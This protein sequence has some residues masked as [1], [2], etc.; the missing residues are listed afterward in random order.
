MTVPALEGVGV[1]GGRRAVVRLYRVDGP[2]RFRSGRHELAPDWRR[3]VATRGA[4][5]LG[6]DGVRIGTVEHLLAALHV[7]GVFAG[8]LIEVIGDELPILDGSAAPWDAALAELGPFPPP[9]PAFDRTATVAAGDRYA[10]H[11]P[12]TR[13]LEVSVAYDDPR[14]GAQRW[15]GGPERWADLLPARTFGFARDA[16]ALRAAGLA[17][18]SSER[19]AIVYHDD[20]PPPSLRFPDEPVR[21]KALDALGDLYLLGVPFAGRVEV[22]RGGHD[23]HLALVRSLA[24]PVRA[25]DPEAATERRA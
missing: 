18:G 21:H 14:I 17:L 23:L 16:D 8:L 4:T 13:G 2:V 5:T 6:D 11:A 25:A 1:H 7:R 10:R 22:R 3:V 20:A 19:N 9:P 24:G 12:G 15:T